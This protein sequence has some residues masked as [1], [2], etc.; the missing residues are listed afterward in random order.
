V[1]VSISHHTPFFLFLLLFFPVSE[2][3]VVVE[4]DSPPVAPLQDKLPAQVSM[5]IV[6]KYPWSLMLCF[7]ANCA[8]VL[9]NVGCMYLMYVNGM[10]VYVV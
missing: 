8:L 5:M 2:V 4:P 3:V 1:C 10:C 9:L 7:T 6:C